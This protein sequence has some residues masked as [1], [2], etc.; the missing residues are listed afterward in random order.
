MRTSRHIGSG[1]A[2]LAAVLACGSNEDNGGDVARNVTF[3]EVYTQILGPTCSSHHSGAA[4]AGNLDM[5]SQ[6]VAYQNLAG[7]A[8]SGPSCGAED[9]VPTRVV[10][11]DY[12]GSLLWQKVAGQQKCGSQMPLGGPY[13]SSAQVT[14]ISSWIDD[15]AQND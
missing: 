6:S 13:L 7:V 11:Y 2:C 1:A 9:P 10:A 12:A 15:G 5:S 14:L 4:P 8:A 3:T